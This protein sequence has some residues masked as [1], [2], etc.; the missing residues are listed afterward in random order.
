MRCILKKTLQQIIS[1]HHSFVAQVKSNQQALLRW[2]E[3]NT[4]VSSAIDTYATHDHN[5]H[6]RH[7]ERRIEIYDDLYEINQEWPMVQRVAKVNATITKH[8][9][10]TQETR[11]YIS[12]LL[13]NAS[14][15]LHIVRSHW[16]IEN[17][18]HYVKDVAYLEDF[19]RMRTDQIPRI[20]SLLRSLAI[21]LQNI[22]KM[23]NKTQSR[24][25]LAWGAL[26]VF[27]LRCS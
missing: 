11:W 1:K 5:T 12:N 7:E 2:L 17:S 18:L 15:F 8:G 16:S 19:N 26:D 10:T 13:I 25:L 14:T 4:T 21:N 24:K 23:N 22:N 20:T 6:G 27:S 3:F 9:V